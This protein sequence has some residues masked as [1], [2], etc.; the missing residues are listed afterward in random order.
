MKTCEIN[1]DTWYS[2][3]ALPGDMFGLVK[4]FSFI[5]RVLLLDLRPVGDVECGDVLLLKLVV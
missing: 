1:Y 5:T 3:V 2:K 4:H